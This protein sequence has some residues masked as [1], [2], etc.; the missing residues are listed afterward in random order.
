MKNIVY[1][2]D[3][4]EFMKTCQDKKYDLAI[5]DPPFFSGPNKSNFYKGGNGKKYNEFQSIKS[6]ENPEQEYSYL[7]YK[8]QLNLF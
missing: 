2:C 1:N 6:W 5:C 8:E 3:C 4:M 7:K